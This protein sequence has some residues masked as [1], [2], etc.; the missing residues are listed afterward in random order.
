MLAPVRHREIADE[1]GEPD[2]GPALQLRVLVPVVVDLPGLVTDHQVV[3][4][5]IEH[6]L[7]DHEVGHQD[8]VHAT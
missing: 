4:T 7:E 6:L 8:L 5:L 1:V 3:Q 2:I